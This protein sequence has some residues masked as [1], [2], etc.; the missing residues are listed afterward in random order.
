MATRTRG[1][2]RPK[3]S[4]AAGPAAAGPAPAL[5]PR[6][7][8]P[9][10]PRDP[11]TPPPQSPSP[12]Q[13][14]GPDPARSPSPGGTP[15]PST[16]C[17]RGPRRTP[18]RGTV[19][20]K[21][22]GRRPRATYA[23]NLLF[24]LPSS[25]LPHGVTSAPPVPP[26]RARPLPVARCASERK[27]AGPVGGRAS[28]PPAQGGCAE[29]AGR[30]GGNRRRQRLCARRLPACPAAPRLPGSVPV[31]WQ[32]PRNRLRRAAD[33]AASGLGVVPSQTPSPGRTERSWTR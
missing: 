20:G 19:G 27:R 11:C 17:R 24:I 1:A 13:P 10:R 26:P 25:P 2:G 32:P 16:W 22:P 30:A 8:R 7:R 31:R 5:H 14:P 3:P 21:R 15:A 28:G 6:P 18:A 9:R 12:H 33:R 23:S 4:W 29:A